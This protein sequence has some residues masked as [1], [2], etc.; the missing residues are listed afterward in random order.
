ML[1]SIIAALVLAQ[2]VAP[3]ST[4]TVTPT[5]TPPVSITPELAVLPAKWPQIAGAAGEDISGVVKKGTTIYTWSEGHNFTE[6][7]ACAPDG[8][9]YFT[10]IPGNQ[11]MQVDA[12]GARI[13]LKDSKGMNGLYFAKDGTLYGCQGNPGA[14]VAIDVVKNETRIVC[15]KRSPIGET[16]VSLG[17]LNDLV[18]DD[19]NGIWFTAPVIGGVRAKRAPDSVY[20]VPTTGGEA[21]EVIAPGEMRA[22]NGV[23]LSPDGK[24]LYVL[25]YST[26]AMMAYPIEGPGKLGAG[27]LFYE[28]PA[29]TR[30]TIGGDGLTVDTQGN[31]YITVP[32]RSAIYVLSPQGKPLGEIRL[33]ERPSNCAL[34]GKDGKTLW[35]TA[36]TGV[37]AIDVEHARAR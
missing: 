8:R 35:I 16:G 3:S 12:M 2:S 23:H 20:Y 24:T 27:K 15:D 9:V 5:A 14:I 17:R 4:P 21:I 18:I 34:G 11:V 29:G 22:P 1:V 30:E 10:D 7:P 25:P 37:Y 6:G 28:I 33:P 32:A 19:D 26:R 13:A 36:S 31:V